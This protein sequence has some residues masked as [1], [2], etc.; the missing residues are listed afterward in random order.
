MNSTTMDPATMLIPDEVTC[1]PMGRPPTM[2]EFKAG[3]GD[4]AY[5]LYAICGFIVAV[6]AILVSLS[7]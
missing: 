4:Y 1:P 7:K 3:L 6:L 2:R 5:G